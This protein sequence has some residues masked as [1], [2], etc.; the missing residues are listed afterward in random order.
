LALTQKA[1]PLVQ[2]RKAWP[3]ILITTPAGRSFGLR[4]VLYEW[5]GNFSRK[6]GFS[7]KDRGFFP[8][9]NL[10]EMLVVIAIIGILAALLLPVL[11]RVKE[12][13]NGAQ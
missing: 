7:K 4:Q 13:A 8:G 11:G 1:S 10:V 5:Q 6:N 3:S 12:R 2:H 9:F